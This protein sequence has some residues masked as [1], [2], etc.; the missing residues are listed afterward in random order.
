MSF[1]P[2]PGLNHA[3]SQGDHFSGSDNKLQKITCQCNSDTPKNV[4]GISFQ[5]GSDVNEVCGHK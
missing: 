1:L 5:I 2:E 4:L 3:S